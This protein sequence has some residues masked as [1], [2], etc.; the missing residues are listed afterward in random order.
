MRYEATIAEHPQ[1]PDAFDVSV[2]ENLDGRLRLIVYRDFLFKT[3]G[4]NFDRAVEFAR[5]E[6][7]KL[8]SVKSPL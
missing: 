4:E 7:G 8:N 2:Y 1:I 3:R 6:L 5:D